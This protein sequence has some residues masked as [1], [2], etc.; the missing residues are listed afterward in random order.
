MTRA[1]ETT[2]VL[3]KGLALLRCLNHA[4]AQ[5]VAQLTRTSRLPRTTVLRLLETLREEGYLV[6]DTGDRRYRL[7]EQ[8]ASLSEG[9]E[10]SSR[11]CKVAA[12]HVRALGA[13]LLWPMFVAT[14]AGDRMVW[15][16]T[17]EPASPMGLRRYGTGFRIPLCHSASGWV[18][19]AF[20]SPARRDGLLVNLPVP[21]ALADP[22][23]LAQVRRQGY[24][25]YSRASQHDEGALAVPIVRGDSAV[26]TL[27]IRYRASRLREPEAV[28]R[29]LRPMRECATAI[30]TAL[31]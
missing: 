24:A 14:L 18:Q 11:L 4:D 3:R 1:P 2:A 17:T 26:A 13:E 9:F 8:V 25:T 5:T 16:Y 20:S 29:F 15:R 30:G 27:A 6:R 19:L 12:P 21:P 31:S 23:A 7:T 22:N 10:P 28:E